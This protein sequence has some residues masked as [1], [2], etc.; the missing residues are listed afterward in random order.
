MA[1][2]TPLLHPRQYFRARGFEFGPAIGA[3][4][5]ATLSLVV[6][7]LAFAVMLTNRLADAGHGDASSAAWG[8]LVGQLA[9]TVVAMLI[10]WV[11]AAGV[12]HLLTRALVS[13]DGTFGDTMVVA[14]WATAPTVL[15]TL[16]AFAFLAV[17]LDGAS[18]SSPQAFAESFQANF[19]ATDGARA[20][21]S[22]AVACWQTY[23]YGNALAVEF[24]DDSGATWLVGGVV[25]FVGWV[26]SIA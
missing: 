17:A 26:I 3:V 11:L 15:T 20:L 9:G 13:H 7:L 16:V 5:A 19:A 24:D 25:A 6:A 4:C 23:F 10:G 12:I 22:F 14:G 21:L 2:R 8:V 1:P 18:L